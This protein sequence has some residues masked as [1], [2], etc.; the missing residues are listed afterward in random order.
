MFTENV[1]MPKFKTLVA[2]VVIWCPPVQ[3]AMADTVALGAQ[4]QEAPHSGGVNNLDSAPTPTARSYFNPPTDNPKA[5][6]NTKVVPEQG[7][8]SGPTPAPTLLNRL[9]FMLHQWLGY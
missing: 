7:S 6:Q 2:V 4:T 1:T 9:K 8:S 5:E 3:L